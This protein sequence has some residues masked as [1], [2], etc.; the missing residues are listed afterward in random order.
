[1]IRAICT[2]SKGQ[3]LSLKPILRELAMPNDSIEMNNAGWFS[4]NTKAD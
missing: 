3:T 2:L 4:L 1:M